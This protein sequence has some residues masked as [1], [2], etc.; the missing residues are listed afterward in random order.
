MRI[1]FCDD[2]QYE[3]HV[4]LGFA[5]RY[6]KEHSIRIEPRPY[7]DAVSLLDDPE[8]NG[9]EAMFLDIYMEGVSG[10]E[11]ARVLRERGYTGAI[12]L[13]TTSRDHFADGF[14]VDASHY[15]LKPVAYNS[16]CEAMRRV[17][18]LTGTKARTVS[19][20]SG[21]DRLSVPVAAIQ[22]AEVFD[23]ETVLHLHDRTFAVRQS[24]SALEDMLGGDPFLRCYRSFIVNMDYVERIEDDSF[25]MKD[26]ARVLIARDGRK[27]IQSRYLAYVFGRMEGL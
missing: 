5:A 20:Q 7:A 14:V 18:R 16:F 26:G 12:V 9:I 10:V 11:A 4:M 17:R 8:A 15:L 27:E 6:A 23:H 22:Y 19:V 2:N 13:C 25:V 1:A 21:H 24:L 3:R